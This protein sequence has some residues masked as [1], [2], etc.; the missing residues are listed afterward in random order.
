[1]NHQYVLKDNKDI[2]ALVHLHQS[3][4]DKYFV[5]YWCDSASPAV[6]VSI[7][8]KNGNAVYRNHHKRRVREILRRH[9]DEIGARRLLVIIKKPVERL[10][11]A[12]EE[13]ELIRLM[14]KA[15][16]EKK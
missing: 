3:V 2:E 12:E 11:F 9:Q 10:A 6:A 16:K 7:S 4:G 5:I 8:K 13:E 14:Q 15:R 1:M